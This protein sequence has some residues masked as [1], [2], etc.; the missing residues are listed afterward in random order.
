MS[1][2]LR[3][4]ELKEQAVR[5]LLEIFDKD[6]IRKE[7]WVSYEWEGKTWRNRID[8]IGDNG[9]RKVL[10]Q[11]GNHSQVEI[12]ILKKFF[13]VN[14]IPYP[15]DMDEENLVKED[16]LKEKQQ[17]LVEIYNQ[18]EKFFEGDEVFDFVHYDNEHEG[19][20]KI[21]KFEPWMI[22]P[23]SNILTKNELF[24]EISLTIDY[25][26]E[27]KISFGIYA[28]Q[29]PAVQKFLSFPKEELEKYLQ[30]LNKLPEGYYVYPGYRKPTHHWSRYINYWQEDKISANKLDYE[31]LKQ[32]RELGQQ[33][34]DFKD[35]ELP[36]FCLLYVEVSHKEII[37][38][39]KQLR[40]VYEILK[41]IKTIDRNIM[42]KIK[43]LPKW[44]WH[45]EGNYMKDLFDMF[46][47]KFPEDKVAEEEFKPI[48]RKLK[49]DSEYL[50]YLEG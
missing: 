44:E 34:I 1:E 25:I 29:K 38:A 22:L 16:S 8:V 46:I 32:M 20:F 28:I 17:K 24:N 45:V 40:P 36:C 42:E 15:D 27:N 7:Q 35:K 43:T 49:K 48:A 31:G 23:T 19:A 50:K 12:I 11:V 9:K 5:K 37:K 2:S 13:E 6:E 10:Y 18:F 47:E 14:Y 30:E 4:K 33:I 39:L 26:D 3:H 21:S 41:T